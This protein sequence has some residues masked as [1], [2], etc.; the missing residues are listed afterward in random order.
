LGWMFTSPTLLARILNK[1]VCQIFGRY[2][3]NSIVTVQNSDDAALMRSLGLRCVK[4]IRGAGVDTEK[5]HP[6][7]ENVG[8]PL[9]ILPARML[10]DKGIKARFVVVGGADAGNPASMTTETLNKWVDEGLVEWWG[11]RTDMPEIYKQSHIVCL[12]SYREGLP[13]VLIEAASC[14][15]PIVTTDTV[16]CRE[17]VRSEENGFLVPV[18]SIDELAEAIQLL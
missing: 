9:V 8:A 7:D 17:V 4:M 3:I 6:A 2:F 13:T 12:P 5:F 11:Q 15:R 14:N 16:G 1:I 18:Q 10:W